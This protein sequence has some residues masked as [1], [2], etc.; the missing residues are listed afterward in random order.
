MAGRRESLR[1]ACASDD[2]RRALVALRSALVEQLELAAPNV[3]VGIAARLQLVI[4][5]IAALD[6]KSASGAAEQVS[7]VADI[8]SRRAGRRAEAS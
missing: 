6:E 2:P 4:E 5:S 1:R 3:V 7:V 8:A